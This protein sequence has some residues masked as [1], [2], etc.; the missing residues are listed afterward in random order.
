ML[1][2][3]KQICSIN[4][5]SGQASS[6]S[7]A[8]FLCLLFHIMLLDSTSQ[9]IG[10]MLERANF[11]GQKPVRSSK[12]SNLTLAANFLTVQ[13]LHQSQT[14]SCA[15]QYIQLQ[16]LYSGDNCC[17]M[18][19][20]IWIA[21]SQTV[22]IGM[23]PCHKWTAVQ[24]VQPIISIKQR[25][26]PQPLACICLASLCPKV[27][28]K[29]RP[30]TAVS[31]VSVAQLATVSTQCTRLSNWYKD[32]GSTSNIKCYLEGLWQ[33]QFEKALPKSA[34]VHCHTPK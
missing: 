15:L 24:K 9:M 29:P 12:D 10:M 22:C 23:T 6:I 26:S 14:F 20:E 18:D 30:V 13:Y 8:Y 19:T 16:E 2:L 4:P 32:L 25:M 33:T 21:Q 31:S 11:L 1:Y 34:V 17:K 28:S 7:C 27:E 3:V 5:F